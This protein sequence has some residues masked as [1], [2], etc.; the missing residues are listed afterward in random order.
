MRPSR[1][2]LLRDVFI[3]QMKLWLD[4][5][6]DLVVSPISLVAAAMD[7]V[8]GPGRHG[9]RFYRILRLGERFDQQ[10]NLFR[11]AEMAERS[12]EGLFAAGEPGD[13]DL[14]GRLEELSTPRPRR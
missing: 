2:V 13:P 14:L 12:E 1:W 3:F 4:G 8:F 6:K 9:Y 11:A 10:L 7:V 5:L